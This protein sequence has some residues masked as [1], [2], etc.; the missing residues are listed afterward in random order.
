MSMQTN[1]NTEDTSYQNSVQENR[2]TVHRT[3]VDLVPVLILLMLSA[4]VHLLGLSHPENVVFDEVHFGGF[5]SAYCCSHEYIFDPHPPHAKLIIAAT[6]RLL[7]F[8]GGVD[9]AYIGESFGKIS[10]VPLRL[11]PAL[12]GVLLPLFIFVLLR[13]LGATT[14]A[15]FGG[16]SAARL[17]GGG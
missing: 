17:R 12:A 3:R 8:H 5:A 7:G 11:A 9:F 6:A 16:P 15:A 2:T 1:N 4:A 14:A 13:Q 10:P